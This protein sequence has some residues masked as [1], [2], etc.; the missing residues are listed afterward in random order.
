MV[1]ISQA[2]DTTDTSG[3]Q[4]GTVEH[5]WM[6]NENDATYQVFALV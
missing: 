3:T 2:I 4:K 1:S 5:G 6:K